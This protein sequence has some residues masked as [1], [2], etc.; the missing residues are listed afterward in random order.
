MEIRSLKRRI[1]TTTKKYA[2]FLILIACFLA[3]AF[4][5]MIY[6][7]ARSNPFG[8][9][10]TDTPEQTATTYSLPRVV[11]AVYFGNH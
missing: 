10:P 2:P 1:M 4:A 8:E 3:V 6:G 9:K 7:F 5:T 11:P